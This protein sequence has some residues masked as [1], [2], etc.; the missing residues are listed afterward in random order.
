MGT[1]DLIQALRDKQRDLNEA[2]GAFARRL[3][4]DRET[5]RK[6]RVGDALPS[7]RTLQGAASAFPDL[8]LHIMD[9]LVAQDA[10]MLSSQ[11]S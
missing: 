4:V 6:V 5:W 9:F 7:R 8:T 3:G 11:A 1:R 2:D 10:R